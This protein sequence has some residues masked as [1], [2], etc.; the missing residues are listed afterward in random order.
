[1]NSL[2]KLQTATALTLTLL[3]GFMIAIFGAVALIYGPRGSLIGTLI[4]AVGLAA[5]GTLI[6]WVIG[7]M[8]I[9]W[10]TRMREIEPGEYEWIQRFVDATAKHAGIKTPKLYIVADG[11]P[12]AFAF[13]RT[14]NDSN[15]AIHTGLLQ[16]LNQHEVEAVLAHEVGHVKHWDVAV[17]TLASM[18]PQIIYY[19]IVMLFTPRDENGNV[20]IMGWILTVIGA[21]LVAFISN[22]LVMYLSRTRELYA[23]HYSAEVTKHP[24][25]LRTALAKIAYGFPALNDTS[26]YSAKRAFYIADPISSSELAKELQQSEQERAAHPIHINTQ[27]EIDHAITWE[28]KQGAIMEI[29]STHPRAYKRIKALNQIEKEQKQGGIK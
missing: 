21:Q 8:L 4:F 26:N 7:P 24:G 13:G 9:K 28:K 25:H 14:P 5:V 23:D 10:T 22:L 27:K 12:N 2:L 1:M 20:S 15:I 11:T 18:I 3:F 29:F 16:I 19:T 17:I 6:Q